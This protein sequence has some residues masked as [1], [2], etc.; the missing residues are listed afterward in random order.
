MYKLQDNAY[1]LLPSTEEN[2][3]E[4]FHIIFVVTLSCKTAAV[5][6]RV[7]EQSNADVILMDWEKPRK[8]SAEDKE[9]A[10]VAWRSTFV[11]NEV[12]EVQ[13]QQRKI[14][15]ETTL[16]WFTFFWVGIGWQF[17]A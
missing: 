15:P 3:Y 9:E 1:L 6:Y 5:L 14:S 10:V 13:S 2:F 17:Y 8:I 11:A 4:I 16:I 7:C 12:N